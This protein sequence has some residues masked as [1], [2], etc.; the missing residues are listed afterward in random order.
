MNKSNFSYLDRGFFKQTDG[1]N[2]VDGTCEELMT[3]VCLKNKYTLFTSQ[4]IVQ[5]IRKCFSLRRNIYPSTT[6]STT[7][8]LYIY[9]ME[10]VLFHSV[11]DNKFQYKTTQKRRQKIAGHLPKDWIRMKH[12]FARLEKP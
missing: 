10:G 3:S 8:S 6:P 4:K 11:N 2:F 5:K 1:L 9:C 12:L 7:R